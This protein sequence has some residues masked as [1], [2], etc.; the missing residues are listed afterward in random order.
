MPAPQF[1]VGAPCWVD[2]MSDDIDRC[3]AF[4]GELFGWEA[5]EAQ[6][7]FGGY[8]NRTK[9]RELVAGGMPKNEAEHPTAWSIYLVTTDAKQTIDEA[10]A[11]GSQV[12]VPA[13]DVS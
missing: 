6:E 10:A 13:M 2:L 4:Y 1:P 3:R 9:D 8:L 5:G 11:R 12:C 7:G